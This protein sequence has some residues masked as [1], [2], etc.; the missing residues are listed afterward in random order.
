MGLAYHL[1][2]GVS[3][4]FRDCVCPARGLSQGNSSS[5]ENLV[6]PSLFFLVDIE[7]AMFNVRR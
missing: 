2:R 7:L 4:G 1:V 6:L 5:P 3:H